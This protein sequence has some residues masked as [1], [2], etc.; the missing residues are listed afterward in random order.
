PVEQSNPLGDIHSKKNIEKV[1]ACIATAP[2]SIHEAVSKGSKKAVGEIM[3]VRLATTIATPVSIN[4]TLK[5][6][7]ASRSEFII[8]DVKTIS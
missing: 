1:A 7:T 2:T 5:S 3:P 8:K 6:T 4:G